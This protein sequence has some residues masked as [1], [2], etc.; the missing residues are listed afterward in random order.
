LVFIGISVYFSIQKIEENIYNT[1][2]KN[3][4]VY[5]D[6]QI[7]AKRD[8]GLTNA[9]NI[10]S[11]INVIEALIYNNRDQAVDGLA[12]LAQ[13][14]KDYTDYNNIKIHIHTSDVKSYLRHWLPE[15]FGDDLSGFRHTIN[16]VKQAKK[17]LG[18]VEVGV[19]GMVMRGLSP[20]MLD[21]D[22]LGSVEFIQ[23]F[24]SIVSAAK[25]DLGA[26]VLAITYHD[27]VEKPK[28]D[29]IKTKDGIVTQ[30]SST[31]N[32]AFLNEISS[33]DLRSRGEYFQTAKYFISKIPVKDFRDKE[34]GYLLAAKPL[35]VVERAVKEAESG[36]FQQIG[37]VLV[38]DLFIIIV[39]IV[40]LKKTVGI[41]MKRLHDQA[42][43]LASGE[44]DLTRSI[45]VESEDE[46]GKTAQKV[47]AFIAKVRETVVAAKG[48]SNENASVSNE[49][50]STAT[51]VGKRA[52]ETSAIV[53]DATA[54]SQ[55][56]KSEL[57]AS[58][59]EA[60]RA[61]EEI[62]SAHRTLG[63]AKNKILKMA[64]EVHES[65]QNENQMASRIEQLSQDAEQ[66]KSVLEIIGD[67]ADQTNLLALNAAIEAARAGEHGRGF[68]VVADEVRKLAERTQKSLVEINAT[69]NVI[70]QAIADTSEQ[71]NRNSKKMEILTHVANEAETEISQTANVMDKA[72]ESGEK[73]V[74]DF[75]ATGE[76]IDAIVAKI[77]EINTITRD[78]TRSI[79]EIASA[80][81][82]LSRMTEQLNQTLSKFKT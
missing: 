20:V 23:G 42:D 47:N 24:N 60:K 32:E 37:I 59:E 69:I 12:R 43:D 55:R 49:L 38:V 79:E 7:I 11:N 58:L 51:Q 9:I 41:P 82:H 65:A 71:M 78:N 77:E 52:E 64:T 19:A 66:V 54:M 39:L 56:T 31:I 13:S 34:V 53:A 35:E 30:N 68:A 14:Y 4:K 18:A 44:G 28:S 26:D 80:A 45:P 16:Q 8:V 27:A 70:V 6:N 40:I 5:I 36:M 81:E 21:G 3:L 50:S 22:Y 46:V 2:S 15:K 67:I 76:Q 57:A 73:T 17:P 25:K 74:A 72:T 62:E 48:A 61:K 1:E 10:A 33:L 75:L 63:Q 29:S